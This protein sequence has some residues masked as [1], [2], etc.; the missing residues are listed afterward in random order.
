VLVLLIAAA[1]AI[2]AG[3]SRLSHREEQVRIA[4]DR[5]PLRLFATAMQEELNRLE[6]L[7]ESHL[8]RIAR[9]TPTDGNIKILMACS[10]LEGLRQVSVLPTQTN[11][12]AAPLHVTIDPGA[13]TG[14]VFPR[15]AFIGMERA[16]GP[17]L[18]VIVLPDEVRQAEVHDSGWLDQPGGPPV[19]WYR[20]SDDLCIVMSVSRER[21]A[22]CMNGWMRGWVKQRFVPLEAWAGG[23]RIVGPGNSVLASVGIGTGKTD[24]LPD[25]V[26]PMNPRFASWQLVSWDG[27]E[28]KQINDVRT[29]A[30]SAAMALLVG[31]L[32]IGIFVQ[33]RR[34][35]KLAEQ[36]VS[37]INR[38]SHELRA[39]LT[40]ILLNV[41]L[42]ADDL[43][44][45]E[46]ESARRLA[47]VQEEG[48]RLSRL[49]DNVLTFSRHEQKRLAM[50]PRPCV[51]ADIIGAVL[52]QF[53]AALERRSVRVE[54]AGMI[55]E[56]CIFDLDAFS[57]ILTNLVSNVEKYAA[58]GCYLG[59]AS[60]LEGGRL[61]VTVTDRGAGIP[62]GE[63]EKIFRPFYR[64]HHEVNEG[65]TGTGLGLSIARELASR[66]EGVLRLLPSDTGAVFE[67][68]I[69]VASSVEAG[70]NSA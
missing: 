4:R 36:R 17:K 12:H 11:T 32:G 35:A 16:A 23:D 13:G 65:S 1:V 42:A 43:T 52:E 56:S 29:V 61:T 60:K 18:P 69:P 10:W 15:P 54:L 66:M 21:V 63:A 30:A 6:R 5:E 58:D 28:T 57:Q 8:C 59:I 33:Q 62:A 46:G 39:P 38:V 14:V 26:L 70:E 51:P 55:E 67:L 37:F 7:Y 9:N 53:S 44:E 24:R 22:E 47:L 34:A 45:E 27:W 3:G 68:T 40:N 2:F 41:D 31:L 48:R 49:I 19:F 64:L 25:F 20:R 50:H